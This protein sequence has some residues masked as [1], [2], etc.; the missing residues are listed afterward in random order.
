MRLFFSLFFILLFPSIILTAQRFEG[1]VIAGANF[2]QIDGDRLFGY[3]KAGVTGGV[4]VTTLLSERWKFSIEMLFNQIGSRSTR[5]DDLT[6]VYDRISLN[7]IEIPL[8]IHFLDW[9][10]HFNAGVTYSQLINYRVIENTGIDI[11]DLATYNSNNIAVTLGATY[12][13]DEHWGF[14]FRWSRAIN[15]LEANTSNSSLIN[16][17]LTFRTIYVF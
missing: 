11:T 10:L 5:N 14:D 15:D 13:K 6:S 1:K 2:A 16:K 12:F 9:K 4:G 3:N 8:L 7:Y 17:W